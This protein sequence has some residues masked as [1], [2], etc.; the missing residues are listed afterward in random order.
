MDKLSPEFAVLPSERDPDVDDENFYKLLVERDGYL[1]DE[2]LQNPYIFDETRKWRDSIPDVGLD[3]YK[4]VMRQ[5]K[6]NLHQ[7]VQEY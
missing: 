3:D 7:Q 2:D 1:S 6:G 5:Y 4:E